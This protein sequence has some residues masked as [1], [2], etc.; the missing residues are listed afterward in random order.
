MSKNFWTL[1]AYEQEKLLGS[2]TRAAISQAHASGL[3]TSHAD[4]EGRIYRLNPDGSREF[5]YPAVFS[6]AGDGVTVVFPDLPGCI[7]CAADED[8]ALARAAEA[9]T[10]YLKCSRQGGD[11]IPLPSPMTVIRPGPK[12]LVKLVKPSD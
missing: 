12:E 1:A 10:L 9:L 4:E 3:A 6:R 2:A 5:Y 7:S 11:T 8:Q